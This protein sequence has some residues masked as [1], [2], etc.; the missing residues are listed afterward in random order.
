[1]TIE[2]TKQLSY[3][4]S[5]GEGRIVVECVFMPNNPAFSTGLQVLPDP[6]ALERRGDVW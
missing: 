3:V 5:V 4:F 1:M 2:Q 6:P